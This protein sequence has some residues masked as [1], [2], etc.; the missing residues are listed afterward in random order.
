MIDDTKAATNQ[1]LN[2]FRQAQG[3]FVSGESLA[4]QLSVSRVSVKSRIDRLRDIGYEIEAV[5]N[6]GY[7]LISEP[8]QLQPAVLQ[9]EL[10]TREIPVQVTVLDECSSTND[11]AMRAL[12]E[13]LPD[14]LAVIA[15]RQRSGRGRLGRQWHSEDSGNLMISFGFKPDREPAYMQRFTVWTG[16]RL[17][18]CLSSLTG[19]DVRAKWPND[20]L[21]NR[22]KLA[23]IL[24][25]ARMDAD[26]IRDLILGLGLNINSQ[27]DAWPDEVRA[28]ATSLAHLQ[29]KTHSMNQVTAEV[30][31]A[32]YQAYN[33]YL[34]GNIDA[35]L[36][37]LWERY[38]AIDGQ[39]VTIAAPQETVTG[40]VIGLD[41]TGALRLK[42]E[43]G[44]DQSF[45]AGDV[46]LKNW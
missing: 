11:E 19:L 18:E 41:K 21:V 12:T 22:K 23:G 7:R 15:R 42:L 6:R 44:S 25:E 1:L 27:V 35:E 37:Y 39:T 4:E 40:E 13:N 3:D 29:D 30:V 38:S 33:A 20:L 36:D 16:L 28:V 31:G 24:T 17:A 32:V 43:N 5:R 9:F 10:F 8:S 14:P 34:D 46:T 2:S 45:S 26:R